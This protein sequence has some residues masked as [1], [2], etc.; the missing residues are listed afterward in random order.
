MPVWWSSSLRLFSVLLAKKRTYSEL[1]PWLCL[2]FLHP[3]SRHQRNRLGEWILLERLGA[4][5]ALAIHGMPL[6][7][8][9][10]SSLIS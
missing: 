7:I 1:L 9:A 6:E 10:S 4:R 3:Q 2:P 5:L 8:S